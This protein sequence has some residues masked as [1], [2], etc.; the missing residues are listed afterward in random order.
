MRKGVFKNI[1]LYIFISF[2][3]SLFL[4]FS[5]LGFLFWKRACSFSFPSQQP[6]LA[7][8]GLSL[9][10]AQL[11]LQ[12]S[13]TEGASRPLILIEGPGHPHLYTSATSSSHAGEGIYVDACRR[14]QGASPL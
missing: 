7:H 10:A 1:F 6:G 13:G 3:F 4:F 5:L 9:P 2:S 12:R 11:P 14:G 8:L